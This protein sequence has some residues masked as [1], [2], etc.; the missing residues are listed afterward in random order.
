MTRL[1]FDALDVSPDPVRVAIE[2]ALWGSTQ[3]HMLLH[4]TVVL[5]DDA[6]QFNVGVLALC[7]SIQN[8]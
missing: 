1:G 4:D 7:G 2:G 6:G 5:S 3:S 8:G